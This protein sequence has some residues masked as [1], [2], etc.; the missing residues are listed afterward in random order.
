MISIVEWFHHTFRV[1]DGVSSRL[2][3]MKKKIMNRITNHTSGGSNE[4]QSTLS[5]ARYNR[6]YNA[7]NEIIP[8]PSNRAHSSSFRRRLGLLMNTHVPQLLCT[9]KAHSQKRLHLPAPLYL[10]P[11]SLSSHNM[12]YRK[13]K[14]AGMGIGK[15]KYGLIYNAD[16]AVIVKMNELGVF[17]LECK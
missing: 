7:R 10:L 14:W 11:L 15:L 4:T 5:G 13:C 16:K 6:A 8:L 9:G 17:G 12:R 2:Q 3:K 1:C